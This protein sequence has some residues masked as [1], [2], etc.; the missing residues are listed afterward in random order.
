[1]PPSGATYHAQWGVGCTDPFP[2]Y[3]PQ[4]DSRVSQPTTPNV[5]IAA[6]FSQP[7]LRSPPYY[8][9]QR[10]FSYNQSFGSGLQPDYGHTAPTTEEVVSFSNRLQSN[11]ERHV[12]ESG[13]RLAQHERHLAESDDRIALHERYI[14]F[15]VN[16]VIR[17]EYNAQDFRTEIVGYQHRLTKQEQ[18]SDDLRNE[19]QRLTSRILELLRDRDLYQQRWFTVQNDLGIVKDWIIFRDVRLF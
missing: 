12:S 18:V 8:Q 2:P 15:L 1:M 17:L 13:D 10:P 16:S 14:N 4:R 19:V 6:Q 5:Q 9:P 3:L 7:S 11:F